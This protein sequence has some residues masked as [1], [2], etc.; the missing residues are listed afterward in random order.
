[1]KIVYFKYIIV[2]QLQKCK[3]EREIFK[4][5]KFTFGSNFVNLYISTLSH[6]N[7]DNITNNAKDLKPYTVFRKQY[8][9]SGRCTLF[10]SYNSF[11]KTTVRTH[12]PDSRCLNRFIVW[13]VVCNKLHVFPNRNK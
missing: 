12:L 13:K 1:M 11:L 7:D 6:Y 2:I 10:I 4:F 8:N 3:E 9:D 5:N